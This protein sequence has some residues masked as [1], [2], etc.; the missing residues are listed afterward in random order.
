MI[1]TLKKDSARQHAELEKVFVKKLKNIRSSGD[2]GKFLS[3]LHNFYAPLENRIFKFITPHVLPDAE[4]RKRSGALLLDMKESGYD[5]VPQQVE[6]LP[7]ISS[8][9][10]AVGA[11]YVMEGSTLGGQII[12]QMLEKHV[13]IPAN[14]LHYFRSYGDQTPQKW[15]SFR[16]SLDANSKQ[17]NTEQALNSALETFSSLHHWMTLNDLTHEYKEL[18]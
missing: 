16:E 8:L 1:E 17:I 12:C 3:L 4:E 7:Q 18:R 13:G 6:N 15:Q 10:E 9:S 2:Y 5:Y 14:C 11:M